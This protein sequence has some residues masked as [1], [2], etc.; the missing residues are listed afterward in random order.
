MR[1]SALF[2]IV[3]S[4]VL[5]A[6]NASEESL[7]EQLV[8]RIIV[9]EVYDEAFWLARG[10]TQ[11]DLKWAVFDGGSPDIPMAAISLSPSWI[12]LTLALI[13]TAI[14]WWLDRPYTPEEKATWSG[15]DEWR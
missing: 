5:A 4:P 8:E 1:Y 3:A 2:T 12:M 9:D 15:D 13:I 14:V 10:I 7:F 11:E 6:G